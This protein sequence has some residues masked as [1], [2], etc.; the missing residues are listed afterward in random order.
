MST[1]RFADERVGKLRDARLFVQ[2]LLRTADLARFPTGSSQPPK[3]HHSLDPHVRLC[4]AP[5]NYGRFKRHHGITHDYAAAVFG[6]SSLSA[7]RRGSVNAF[8]LGIARNHVLRRLKR[9][10]RLLSIDEATETTRAEEQLEALS[11]REAIESVQKAVLSLPEHYREVV[12]LCELQEMSYAEAATVLGCAIGTVRSRLHRARTML[13]ERL[14]PT[15]SEDL[16]NERLKSAR[17]FA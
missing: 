15:T 6:S 1:V 3:P 8:L 5:Q 12:V 9:E 4:C 10:R 16:L 7:R 14:R 2:S 17:C 13:I 11:R